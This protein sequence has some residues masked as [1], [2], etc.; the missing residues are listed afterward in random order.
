M[1][2]PRFSYASMLRSAE[3]SQLLEE[4][5]IELTRRLQAAERP[6]EEIART[7]EELR[8]LG[9]DL[10]SFD[11]SDDFQVWCGDWIAPKAPYELFVDFRYGN[12]EAIEVSLLFQERAPS[13]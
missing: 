3:R 13:P 7:I 1:L 2:D 12:G 11:A 10:W 6:D 9:H 4:L 5:G 8:H